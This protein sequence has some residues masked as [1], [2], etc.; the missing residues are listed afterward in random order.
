ML[1]ALL[2]PCALMHAQSATS[3]TKPATTPDAEETIVLSPFE[4]TSSNDEGYAAATT[5]A[6]NRLNTE[7]RDVG[8]SITV[9]TSQFLRD[10]GATDN[11]SLLQRIG[12]AE[13][14]GVNGN[15]AGSG[16]T[17][18]L[19]VLAEDDIRPNENTRIRGL[20]AADNTRDFFRSEIPWDSYNTDRID[21]QRG[22][23]SILFGQGSPAGIINSSSNAASFRNSGELEL[24]Y[25]SYGSA[26]GSLDW[27]QVLVDHQVAIRLDALDSDQKYEQKPAFSKDKRVSGAIRI[28]PEFLSKNGNQTIFKANFEKGQVDSNNPRELPPTDHI[29]PWFN[30]LHQQGL[31]GLLSWVPANPD[32]TTDLVNGVS[33]A[34]PNFNPNLP[35]YEPYF[36]NG[37]FLNDN[38]PLTIFQNG[39]TNGAAGTYKFPYLAQPATKNGLTFPYGGFPGSWVAIGGAAQAAVFGLQPYANGGAFKDASITDPSVFNFYKNLIDGDTKKEWQRFWQGS[40]N[41]TQTFLDDQVG[42]S[43]DYHKEHY[44][45]GQVNL[46][47]GAVPLYVDVIST[48]NDGS[49][50][51]TASKN[52]G[53]GTPFVVS[54]NFSNYSWASDREN[55]RITGFATRDFRKDISGILGEIIGTHTLTGL[56]SDD[57]QKTNTMSWQHYGYLGAQGT[58]VGSLYNY[59]GNFQALAPTQVIYLG[60]SLLGKSLQ[61]ANIPRI[62]GNPTIGSNPISYF[63][64]TELANNELPLSDP[65][66]YVGWAGQQ[67]PTVTNSEDSAANR[68]ALAYH[69]GLTRSETTSQALVWQG[70]MLDGALVGTY[71]WRRDINKSWQSSSTLGDV[72]D[73]NS[74]NFDT[75]TLPTDPAGRVE[76]QSRSYSIVAHLGDL[77]GVKDF[78]KK[79]PFNVS[80]SYN[81]STNFEPDSSRVNINGDHIGAPEGKTVDRGIVIETRDGKYSLKINR[82]ETTIT[83][84]SNPNGAAFAA[85]LAAFVGNTAYYNNVFYYHNNQDGTHGQSDPSQAAFN[86]GIG[87][88]NANNAPAGY[89]FDANGVHSAAIDAV[90]NASTQAVRDWETKINSEFPNFFKAWGYTSLQALQSGNLLRSTVQG[91]PAESGFAIT[92][93]A[94]SKGWEIE[95]NANPVR[96]WRISLNATRTDAVRTSIGDPALA[97]FMQD[98]TDM[99]A[100]PGGQQHWYWGT[101]D[102]P[103]IKQ[104]YFI[105]YGGS[106]P[107]VGTYYYGLKSMENVSVGELAKWRF[108]LTTNYDF[109]QAWAKGFNIGGGIRYS[110]A[111]VIG[112]PPGGDPSGPPPYSPDL[113]KPYY[114]PSEIYFDAWIGYRHKITNKI[115]WSIQ[116]NAQ[117]IGKGDYLIPV[118][119]QGPINGVS[120]PAAYRIG[121]SQ[122]FTLTNRFEF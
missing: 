107:A 44:E 85:Q 108:N 61:G 4:V 29:T 84:G 89:F 23:N 48:N 65:N 73:L 74:I 27:N 59:A 87:G 83:N 101:A 63:D 66:A 49:S 37:Q 53:F 80:L 82:Y 95:L 51:A 38:F 69:A 106:V 7:L 72:N 113:S 78:A 97:Q 67:T 118:S 1:P 92:E 109:T 64:F 22:P 35:A 76:V 112:Y 77:P 75:L 122:A 102:V 26:R 42:F 15:Y 111:T 103:T 3:P 99:V 98:T 45:D 62:T 71:G 68:K 93:N 18:S 41:L 119:L 115:N 105:A 90:Q 20:A 8:S 96:N 9:V 54:N 116:L 57:S 33:A 52:P 10:T 79:L 40:V 43:A 16:S 30:Q 60:G 17:S 6:G 110:S 32:T 2:L 5:L 114:G 12:S 94:K 36:T 34:R 121:P 24:R 14:G 13:V 19:S 28:Q 100:G 104:T 31:N 91:A 50:A 21:I 56:L 25:G 120:S 88:A 70:K 55:K 46:F 11:A 81:V 117:N 39:N 47:G 86:P 58:E